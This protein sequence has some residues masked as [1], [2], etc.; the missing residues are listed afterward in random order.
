[1]TAAGHDIVFLQPNRDLD[2]AG[3]NLDDRYQWDQGLPD[4][5]ALFLEWHWPGS[6]RNTTRCGTSGHTCD[7]HRQEE[8]LAHYTLG[9]RTRTLLCDKDRRLPAAS[10]PL[11]AD[12]DQRQR[13]GRSGAPVDTFIRKA[14]DNVVITFKYG[15][16]IETMGEVP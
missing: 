3:C 5:D 9:N 6:G 12:V 7:L 11:V 16:I 10:P 2:E 14:V 13:P 8:L 4:I 15:H 1:M